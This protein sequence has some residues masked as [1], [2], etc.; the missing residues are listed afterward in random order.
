[1]RWKA[2]T[3]AHPMVG[4]TLFSDTLGPTWWVLKSLDGPEPRILR[5]AEIRDSGPSS[6]FKS[7]HV[8]P[9]V[10][11]N[12]VWP[13]VGCANVRAFQR[14]SNQYRTTN[15][16][17]YNNY[18]VKI[19]AEIQKRTPP[20]PIC[21]RVR[22]YAHI[23][24]IT[25]NLLKSE[26]LQFFRALGMCIQCAWCVRILFVQKT[27]K[28]EPIWFQRRAVRLYTTKTRSCGLIWILF[29]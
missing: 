22:V 10:S 27:Q 28:Y 17:A 8:G 1:M 3:L 18:F 12:E 29:S 26:N 13:T 15:T 6:D 7:R 16:R 4:Q 14:T 20:S 19:G 11:E 5:S 25:Q 21:P 2:L 23:N 24:H 9:K